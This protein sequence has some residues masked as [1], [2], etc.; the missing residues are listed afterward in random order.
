MNA[1]TPRC[2]LH[3]FSLKCAV[4]H[5]GVHF[6]NISRRK[7]GK[8]NLQPST[9]WQCASRQGRATTSGV[10]CYFYFDMCFA[11]QRHLIFSSL[12]SPDGCTPDALASLLFL[13]HTLEL[14]GKTQCFATFPPVCAPV[15]SF[16]W[17]SLSLCSLIFFLLPF[18]SLTFP[19]RLSELKIIALS[20]FG[21]TALSEALAL[22]T[23]GFSIFQSCWKFDF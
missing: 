18:S 1:S 23:S 7:C 16:A 19:T 10:L 15:S 5:Y 20:E 17:L 6:L 11:L 13:F 2:A 14:Q 8:N 9:F 21:L 4:H 22:P 3:T 12:I